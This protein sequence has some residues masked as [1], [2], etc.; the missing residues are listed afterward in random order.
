MQHRLQWRIR[1]VA[2][3]FVFTAAAGASI[4]TSRPW[5][6][7]GP[8][9]RAQFLVKDGRGS[10][11]ESQRY[12]KHLGVKE[13]EYFVEDFEREFM[14]DYPLVTAVFH[15]EHELGFWRDMRCTEQIGRGFGGCAVTNYDSAE[16]VGEAWNRGTVAMR[17]DP[18]G[19]TQFYVFD[20]GGAL[21]T[22]AVLDSEWNKA[23]PQ[24]CTNC[25]G[26]G[27][28]SQNGPGMGAVFR[29][30]DPGQLT[31]APW[32]E[33][34]ETEQRWFELNQIVKM[35]ND[36]IRSEAEGAPW[37]TDLARESVNRYIDELY[38]SENPPQ[39]RNLRDPYFVP[40]SW[41]EVTDLESQRK[42]EVLWTE[43]VMPYCMNCHRT[44][45]FRHEA[46]GSFQMLDGS[47]G[48]KKLFEKYLE[49]P[50][51]ELSA[52]G[53]VIE[54]GMR[55]MPHSELQYNELMDDESALGAIRAWLDDEPNIPPEVEVDKNHVFLAANWQTTFE[56][57][58]LYDANGDY[59]DV[60]WEQTAGPEPFH[61]EQFP[62]FSDTALI[63][64]PETVPEIADSV[65]TLTVD[66][67][68]TGVV[69]R[70]V[71]V[72]LLPQLGNL[73]YEHSN[74]IFFGNTA[75][76]YEIPFDVTE[77]ATIVTVQVYVELVHPDGSQVKAELYT[78]DGQQIDLGWFDAPVTEH[79]R[80]FDV[81]QLIG[82]STPGTWRVR[83]V[84]NVDESGGEV[85]DV[86]IDFA[87]AE[88]VST[89]SGP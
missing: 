51:I 4:A 30:F 68:R 89:D 23:V 58:S 38:I 54:P 79:Y 31:E 53:E 84:D 40:D 81:S 46:F 82:T 62:D 35:A 7:E 43:V 42:N 57:L 25:H 32:S 6:P 76:S 8:N 11:E 44:S 48:G 26:G 85:R 24:V 60:R 1:L 18:E 59:L 15:N 33:R 70:D 49:L 67:R 12:Y 21:S 52:S 47:S 16:S 56:V 77:A 36:A 39:H 13:F 71:T 3:T 55:V 17:I 87:V 29:E 80:T 14:S 66:D 37:G 61:F 65:F 78:P 28:D 75:S 2:V 88:D 74:S 83:L 86:R 41:L 22:T 27:Y 9:L 5:E 34:A 63:V 73:Q 69:T 64:A 19:R 50:Q 45:T 10:R 72:T 20:G